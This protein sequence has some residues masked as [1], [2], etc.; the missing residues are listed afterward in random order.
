M[1]SGRSVD[2]D[3]VGGPLTFEFLDLAEDEQVLEAWRGGCNH[4]ERGSR[5]RSAQESAD[6]LQL[7]VVA[8]GVETEA[9]RQQLMQAGCNRAQGFLLGKPMPAAQLTELLKPGNGS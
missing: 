5:S 8:E 2:D 4:R 9:Q 1:A 7:E 3:Q 6:P